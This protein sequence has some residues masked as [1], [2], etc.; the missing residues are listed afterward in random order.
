MHAPT[1]FVATLAAAAALAIALPAAAA[2]SEPQ[3]FAAAQDVVIS[4]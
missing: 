4:F 1:A 3:W 2:P